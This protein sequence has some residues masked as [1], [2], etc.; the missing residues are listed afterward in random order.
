M[1]NA[2]FE[3]RLNKKRFYVALAMR[4]M[5]MEIAARGILVGINDYRLKHGFVTLHPEKSELDLWT[6][7]DPLA[8][9]TL[10]AE[11]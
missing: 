2:G 8:E 11:H 4:E 6:T 9:P 10:S 3:N 5:G 1:F 7:K